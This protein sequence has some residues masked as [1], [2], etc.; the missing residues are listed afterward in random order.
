MEI[1]YM[2]AFLRCAGEKQETDEEYVNFCV[3]GKYLMKY[4]RSP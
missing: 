1:M 2:Y 4:E 3:E